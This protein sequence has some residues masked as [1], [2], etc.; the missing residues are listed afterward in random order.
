[1]LGLTGEQLRE[2][3]KFL[4]VEHVRGIEYLTLFDMAKEHTGRDITDD[5]AAQVYALLSKAQ[6][7]IVFPSLP[8]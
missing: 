3:A 2:Y 4:A 8:Q 1:M 5:E 6:I 7:T